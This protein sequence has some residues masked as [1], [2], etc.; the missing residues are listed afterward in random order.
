MLSATVRDARLN[1][2]KLLKLA[3]QGHEIV[4]RNRDKPVAKLV[5]YLE[6]EPR[7]FPDLSGL[8]DSL[9]KRGKSPTPAE[10]LIRRDRDDR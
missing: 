6:P 9:R 7:P 1:L 5:P 8:R 4:I 2:S 3:Q 10:K